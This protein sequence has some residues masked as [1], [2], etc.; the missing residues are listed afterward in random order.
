MT[1]PVVV[2]VLAER[3]VDKIVR[4]HERKRVG[5]GLRLRRRI[6]ETLLRIE[7]NPYLHAAT[8][9]GVRHAKTK[10]FQYVVHYRIRSTYV[11]IIAIL[12]AKRNS[13]IWKKRD[14]P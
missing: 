5:L 10:K 8:L 9:H 2:R 6:D 11:E 7:G 12:H 13:T 3:E 14:Q 1:L 4:W